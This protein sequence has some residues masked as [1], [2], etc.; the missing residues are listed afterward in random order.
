MT[1]DRNTL[2]LLAAGFF[3]WWFSGPPAPSP[4]PFAPPADRPVLR[5]VA[6]AAK[7]LLWVMMFAEGPPPAEQPGQLV[8]A[9]GEIGADGFPT[10]NHGRGL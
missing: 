1:F 8:H 9:H 10:I 2:L 7:S 3:L 5:W 4:Q 6:R